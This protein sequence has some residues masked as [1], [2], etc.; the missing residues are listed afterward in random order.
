MSKVKL[1]TDL[2]LYRKSLEKIHIDSVD[3]FMSVEGRSPLS[4]FED[5]YRAIPGLPENCP[6][7][8]YA[9]LFNEEIIG[10]AWV[11]EEIP[12]DQYYILHF[13]IADRYRRCKLGTMALNALDEL[14]KDKYNRSELLVSSTNFAGLNFWV[15][16]GYTEI[17]GVYPPEAQ[18]TLSVEMELRKT[19]QR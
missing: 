10:Y 4:P 8:C 16:N 1:I 11:M 19:I 17:S 3:Y 13:V 15:K 14:F 6:I 2:N 18:N 5:I 12:A 7:A 9:F